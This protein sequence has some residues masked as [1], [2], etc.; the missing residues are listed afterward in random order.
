VSLR[1]DIHSAFESIAPPLGGMPERVVQTVLADN[2]RRRRKERMLFRVRTPLSL[3]AVFMTIALVAAVLIGGRLIGDWN[4]SHRPAPAAPP[5]ATLAELE[6]RRLVLPTLGPNDA[7]PVTGVSN[8][9]H[10]FGDGP[11]FADGSNPIATQWGNYFDIPY[12]TAPALRGLVLIRARDLRSPTIRVLFV[13]KYVAGPIVGNDP[14]PKA[15]AQY[16]EALLDATKPPQR[17]PQ[18]EGVFIVRQGLPAN[19]SACF[20]FQID[21]Q[22]FTETF[23]GG[24]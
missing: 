3:V 23:T 18:H 2:T 24:A 21:G 20:G 12:Y 5:S 15:G 7:C 9:N 1:R 4:A 14:S 16:E 17:S 19:A 22:G 13:G 6:A 11:V 10:Q 8:P